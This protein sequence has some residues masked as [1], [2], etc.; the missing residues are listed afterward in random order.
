MVPGHICGS[1]QGGMTMQ[2]DDRVALVTGAGSGIGQASAILLAREGARVAALGRTEDELKE[3]VEKI[4]KEGGQA[5]A[6]HADISDADEMQ[7]AV[8]RV[9][10]RWGRI[11]IVFANA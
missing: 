10:D 6:V 2:L 4:E 5:I 11:D 3:T 9:C 1:D 7:A 8:R